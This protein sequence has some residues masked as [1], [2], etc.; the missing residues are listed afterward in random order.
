[1]FAAVQELSICLKDTWEFARLDVPKVIFGSH[2][3][4][5]TRLCLGVEKESR[6]GKA[7]TMPMMIPSK[8]LVEPCMVRFPLRM[9]ALS[10][11]AQFGHCFF[12]KWIAACF[13]GFNPCFAQCNLFLIVI[14]FFLPEDIGVKVFDRALKVTG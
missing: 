13:Q 14:V 9:K 3:P 10:I 8:N 7:N 2:G 4:G 12:I 11:A 5:M 6:Y 1:M